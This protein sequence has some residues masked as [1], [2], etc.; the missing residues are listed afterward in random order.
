VIERLERPQRPQPRKGFGICQQ[1]GM[2]VP[3]TLR[4]RC[5]LAVCIAALPWPALA[6]DAAWSAM[7]D[8]AIVLFRHANAP[9]G[10]DP[11]GFKL[12]DC[13]TQRNLDEAGRA[14]ARRIGQ[15]LRERGIVV[16]A[17]RS[18]QWCRARETADLAFPGQRRDEAA[19]N[20]FF[21][22][23]EEAPAQTAAAQRLLSRWQG[24]GV[25]VVVTHQV[26]I[27][28]L[29]GV[30][31]M[32]GEGVVARMVDGQLRVLGRVAPW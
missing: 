13:R 10:G 8:G 26:N 23:R 32:S 1:C 30:A 27:T 12:D 19:F 14:Q 7:G 22:R 21:N 18:S 15:A 3:S 31:P 24:P 25:M 16:G 20:S 4:R 29:T 6:D 2:T 5:L 17:V 11:P 9:G 28:A